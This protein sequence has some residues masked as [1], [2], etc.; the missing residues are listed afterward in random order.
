MTEYP[1]ALYLSGW[2]DLTATVTVFSPD[3]EENARKHGYRS[4]NEDAVQEEEPVK[5]KRT[6]KAA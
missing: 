5:P 2:T 1:K 3:E 4:L 6:R